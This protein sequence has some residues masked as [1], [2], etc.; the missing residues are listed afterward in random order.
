M[1]GDGDKNEHI[2]IVDDGEGT[3]A[4]WCT[5]TSVWAS[6]CIRKGFWKRADAYSVSSNLEGIAP[7]FVCTEDSTGVVKHF[8]SV[9]KA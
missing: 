6:A 1:C 3:G 7:G 9:A 2:V 4:L 8:P 5:F